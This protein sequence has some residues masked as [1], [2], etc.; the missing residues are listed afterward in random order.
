MTDN[1]VNHA[2]VLYSMLLLLLWC[3]TC[4]GCY[5]QLVMAHMLRVTPQMVRRAFT[6]A[7]CHSVLCE[8]VCDCRI[9]MRV[10]VD[11]LMVDVCVSVQ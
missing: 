11:V 2:L 8:W 5:G 6:C 10:M 9:D 1:A 4:G 3:A 7:P